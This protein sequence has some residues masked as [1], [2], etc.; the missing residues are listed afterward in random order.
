MTAALG[1]LATAVSAP[2]SVLAA[3][4]E[5]SAAAQRDQHRQQDQRS[6]SQRPNG[7]LAHRSLSSA[8][9]GT[10]YVVTLGALVRDY[11]GLSSSP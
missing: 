11:W 9:G 1:D 2:S 3:A 10:R 5:A 6:A 8:E 7:T 4:R